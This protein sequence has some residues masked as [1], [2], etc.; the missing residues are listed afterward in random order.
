MAETAVKDRPLKAYAVLE[1]S[2]NTG[3]IYFSKHRIEALKAGANEYGGG[4]LYGMRCSRAP[5]A[6]EWAT[7]DEDVPAKLMIAHGWHFECAGCG[8]RIDEDWLAEEDLPLDGV[9]GT[10]R[11]MVFCTEICEAQEH[12]RKVTARWHE[13]RMIGILKE[14]VLKRFPGV[15]FETKDNWKEHAYATQ[16]HGTWYVKQAVVSFKFPGQKYGPATFRFD[17]DYHRIGPVKPHFSCC[18]GDIEAFN[19][20]ADSTSHISHDHQAAPPRAADT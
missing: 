1:D 5:W 13:K 2:E 15:E 11:S 12:L 6:D 19:A 8:H 20:F 9:I 18:H 3:A 10:Q 14:M 4:E 7:K 17:L 16:D